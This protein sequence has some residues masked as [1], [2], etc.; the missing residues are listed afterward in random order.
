MSTTADRQL[1]VA[2][3]Y[4]DVKVEFSGSPDV[5]F[6][7]LHEFIAKEVP[8]IDLAKSISV[9][10]SL[11]DLVQMFRDYIRF[12]EE[13]PRVW[14]Q[15]RKLSDKDVIALQLVA[16]RAAKLSGRAKGDDMNVAELQAATS[17]IAKTIGSRLSELTK[18]GAVER[19]EGEGTGRYRI[20]T[21]GVHWLH[22]QLVKKFPRSPQAP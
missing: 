3:S 7:S 20:T 2:V 12:T 18:S 8:N 17:L 16:A 19:A 1:S 21:T 13:G 11:N 6:R 5:V 22:D 10:Y 9:N 4:G 15:D 14:A